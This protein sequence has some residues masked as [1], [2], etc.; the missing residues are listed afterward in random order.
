MG[1]LRTSIVAIGD[2]HGQW[3]ELWGA[4]R[5]SG[6]ASAS[7]EPTLPLLSGRLEVVLSGDLVHF[8][9]QG[10]YAQAVGAD[11]FDPRDPLQLRRAAKAQFR[12]L[13]RF[14]DFVQQASGHV[15]IILG[16]H[17]EVA[18]DHRYILGTRDGLEHLEFE[19]ARGGLAVPDD[20]GSWIASFP[21]QKLVEGVQFAH[22][23][24]LPGMQVYDDFFYHDPDTKR[25]WREKPELSHQCGYRFGVYGH[26]VMPTGIHIDR[27]YGFAMIDALHRRE[28]LELD[29][30]G[31][32]LYVAV[33]HF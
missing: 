22:A 8:K 1:T 10:S 27:E 26:T 32:D 21:R 25:W 6:A 4:L 28:Y 19:P 24:P 29:F 11:T 7:L 14:K 12:E 13:Y 18:L 30:E 2:V 23:G 31:E 16:N 15:S 5:A 3:A 20:L 17:D 9:D 33:A